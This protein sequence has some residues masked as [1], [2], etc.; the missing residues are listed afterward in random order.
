MIGKVKVAYAFS[1]SPVSDVNRQV[2]IASIGSLNF[3]GNHTNIFS[4]SP[5]DI[6]PELNTRLVGVKYE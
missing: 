3:F 5:A 2:W 1:F 4:R 6:F